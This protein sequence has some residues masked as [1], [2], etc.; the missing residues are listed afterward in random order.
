MAFRAENKKITLSFSAL[1]RVSFNSFNI[2]IIIENP[3][4]IPILNCFLQLLPDTVCYA[5][6]IAVKGRSQIEMNVN[7]YKGKNVLDFESLRFS[8]VDLNGRIISQILHCG[9]N[10][11]SFSTL[12]S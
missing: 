10:L 6:P 9:I 2:N 12:F 7:A 5:I 11:G 4:N 8:L 1:K 3:F